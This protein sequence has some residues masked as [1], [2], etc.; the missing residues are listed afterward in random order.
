MFR[1]SMSLILLCLHLALCEGLYNSKSE[2]QS[3]FEDGG[4]GDSALTHEDGKSDILGFLVSLGLGYLDLGNFS[5]QASIVTPRKLPSPDDPS[6]NEIDSAD[7]F[8]SNIV[9]ISTTTGKVHSPSNNKSVSPTT[10][11]EDFF[12]S[13]NVNLSTTSE[14]PDI[15]WGLFINNSGIYSE[16]DNGVGVFEIEWGTSS[17]S[18]RK[19]DTGLTVQE[20]PTSLTEFFNAQMSLLA[21]MW[22]NFSK[23]LD[24][25]FGEITDV[26]IDAVSAVLD[27]I[28][29]VIQSFFSEIERQAI[30][31]NS[32]VKSIDTIHDAVSHVLN[33]L[34]ETFESFFEYDYDYAYAYDY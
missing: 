8:P 22:T 14:E 11:N 6:I 19:T 16:P 12:S 34:F 23:M 10:G 33:T 21:P 7:Y 24:H 27:F 1:T 4:V 5:V 32:S 9:N 29:E 20:H 31:A 15:V 18:T 30:Q 17:N 2:K 13:E 26:L 3:I 28:W 25:F